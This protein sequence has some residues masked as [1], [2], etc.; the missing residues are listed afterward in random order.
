[1][2]NTLFH[3]VTAVAIGSLFAFS[4]TA[5]AS[6]YKI[7]EITHATRLGNS[8]ILLAQAI[9]WDGGISGV[10]LVGKFR[11]QQQLNKISFGDQRNTL[12]TELVG[13]TKDSVGYY[14]S[15]ND[16]DLGGTGALLVYLRETGSRTDQQITTMSADDIR[17]TV[18]VEVAAQTGRGRDLQGLKNTQLIQLILGQDSYIRGVLLVGKFRTQQ[19]LNKMSFGDQ[20]N[21]LITELVGRTKD[22]VGYYQSLNDYDLGGT[23]ALL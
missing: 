10:L 3:K 15:L 20:R 12:I 13:R 23:G 17:N 9:A 2:K 18:I 8:E 19:Q 6:T 21:T 5:F 1:M 22:S 7:G 14:Q 4:G 16:Y 11:T